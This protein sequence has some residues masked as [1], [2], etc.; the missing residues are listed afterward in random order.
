MLI[1]IESSAPESKHD[2]FL[3]STEKND[4]NMRL[5][6]MV[7]DETYGGNVLLVDAV[8]LRVVVVG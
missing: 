7:V 6:R 1:R 5:Y 2:F 3:V 8:V 4:N